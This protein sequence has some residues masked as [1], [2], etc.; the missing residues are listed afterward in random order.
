MAIPL[1]NY[2]LFLY[3]FWIFCGHFLYFPFSLDLSVSESSRY[4]TGPSGF[5]SQFKFYLLFQNFHYF[6]GFSHCI[7]WQLARTRKVRTLHIYS[8]VNSSHSASKW[9]ARTLL[10]RTVLHTG[11]RTYFLKFLDS[12]SDFFYC[13]VR[14]NCIFLTHWITGLLIF[15][16]HLLAG[17]DLGFLDFFLLWLLDFLF[18]ACIVTFILLEFRIWVYLTGWGPVI[19]WESSFGCFSFDCWF[20][21]TIFICF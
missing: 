6:Q 1:G 5:I 10:S 17:S 2:P 13:S 14:L 11:L 21:R 8:S 3:G 20:E 9:P 16:F 4:P 15:F 7:H 18:L 19:G 12:S